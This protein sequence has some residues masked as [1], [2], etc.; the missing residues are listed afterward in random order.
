MDVIAVEGKSA[1]FDCPISAPISEVSM[2]LFFKSAKGG[3]P[4]YR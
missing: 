4:F 3:I 2:V 1:S